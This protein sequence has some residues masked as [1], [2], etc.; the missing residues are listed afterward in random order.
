MPTR[1][2]IYLHSN[3][4]SSITSNTQP[5]EETM[6]GV[7]SATSSIYKNV[8][9]FATS[10]FSG[11]INTGVAS[12]SKAFPIVAAVVI[13]AKI[14]DKVLTVGFGHLETYKGHYEYSMGWN[15]FKTEIGMA[16]NPVGTM[17][18]QLHIGK[19]NEINNRR[20]EEIRSLIGQVGKVGV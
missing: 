17:L 7:F 9:Q 19:Q 8:S 10:G 5:K 18:K 14:A 11:Y 20:Q 2:D 4:A 3:Q 13:G 1:Y 16:L 15:N 6:D 12:L